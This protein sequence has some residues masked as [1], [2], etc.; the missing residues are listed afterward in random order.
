MLREP[1]SSENNADDR[2][3][4]L[5][6]CWGRGQNICTT[7][8]TLESH[9]RGID[10]QS[11]PQT[12]KD[13]IAIVRSLGVRYLWIDSLCIIQGDLHDW[14]VESAKMATV[15]RDAY[16]VL[17]AAR[18]ESD[19]QGF[20]GSRLRADEVVLTLPSAAETLSLLL[21]P[22][23]ALRWTNGGGGGDPVCREPL[24]K[25]AW[26]LQERYLPRRMLLYGSE[27][28]F[29]ECNRTRASEDGD[30]IPRHGD[31]LARIGRTA[32]IP[33]SVFN[34]SSRDLSGSKDGVN[35]LD[36]YVM[37]EDYTRRGITAAS[38][39]LPALI[40]LVK[41]MTQ[42]S[43][44][45]Y[46][47]GVWKSSLIEGL[48]WCGSQGAETLRHPGEYIA[49][50]WSWASVAGAVQ[51][52]MYTW[53]DR[54][55]WMARMSDFEALASYVEHG[56]Q[57]RDLEPEGRLKHGWLRVKGALLPVVSVEPHQE[58]PPRM[59]QYFGQEPNRSPFTN[60]VIGLQVRTPPKATE[61]W[62]EG[63][64]DKPTESRSNRQLFVIFLSRLPFILED[65][66][67]DHR[68]G[69]IVEK[70]G[71]SEQ[72]S[73]VGFVDGCLLWKAHSKVRRLVMKWR[74]GRSG[75]DYEV[76]GFPR[77]PLDENATDDLR[78]NDQANNPLQLEEKAIILV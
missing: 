77:P 6:H 68:F 65:G 70:A 71:D 46:M 28:A 24:S 36:W 44:D 30:S 64:F 15:Y 20:L 14:Q 2:Y 63:G 45:D 74:H 59:T 54:A 33:T 32:N 10:I 52:P 21:Q 78:P 49:P 35:H 22:P 27:Q 58:T 9:K 4:A 8:A 69:L 51:F 31:Q 19:T 37:I 61:I 50:S 48:M 17:G 5:S 60:R 62:V 23:A 25:R 75:S 11:L 53:Y 16:L 55:T 18:G 39:R 43:K 76:A 41:A 29:W 42:C 73:R 34:R 7:Q 3:V 13:A 67:I 66:F 26:C 12:F 40:G 56:F 47:A 38:D 1:K 72:Y 57:L